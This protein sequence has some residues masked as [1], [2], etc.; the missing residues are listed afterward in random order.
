[1]SRML[2]STSTKSVTEHVV[3]LCP[4]A[5]GQKPAALAGTVLQPCACA[6]GI[7]IGEGCGREGSGEVVW[8]ELVGRP[9]A[10]KCATR[11]GRENEWKRVVS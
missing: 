5:D 8:M 7:P 4:S 10:L 3:G 2:V 9:S 1:M 11:A 6:G